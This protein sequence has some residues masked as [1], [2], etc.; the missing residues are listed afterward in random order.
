[1]YGP[2]VCLCDSVYA[3]VRMRVHLC[4]IIQTVHYI[5]TQCVLIRHYV[6]EQKNQK[7]H[8]AKNTALM[9]EILFLRPRKQNKVGHEQ[10]D[11]LREVKL[12]P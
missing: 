4:S 1:M 6:A 3:C 11:E 5:K 8:R 7:I 10:G 9:P 2:S 12:K